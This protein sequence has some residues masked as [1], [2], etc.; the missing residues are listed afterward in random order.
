MHAVGTDVAL[1]SGD[2]SIAVFDGHKLHGSHL[3]G[4]ESLAGQ[5]PKHTLGLSSGP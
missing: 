4:F 3:F 1:G 5:Q 2:N